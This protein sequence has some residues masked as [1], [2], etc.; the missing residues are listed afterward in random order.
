MNKKGFFLRR[1]IFVLYF[2][3]QDARTPAYAKLTAFLALA[4]LLSPIDLIPDFIPFIGYLDDLIIVPFLLHIAFRL[5]PGEVKEAGWA[6][7]RQHRVKVQIVL[8]ILL[9]LVIGLLVG[10]YF[11]VSSFFHHF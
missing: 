6:K 10:I 7:V 3:I 1:E 8:F 2:G 9:L 4:Y 5:L 11:L